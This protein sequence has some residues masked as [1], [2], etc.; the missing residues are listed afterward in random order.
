MEINIK[1]YLDWL[2]EFTKEYNSFSDDSFDY[3]DIPEIDKENS[4][5]EKIVFKKL[6]KLTYQKIAN[7]LFKDKN[8]YFI[9]TI[10][11]LI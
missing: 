3:K 2:N 5:F 10:Y 6:E 11:Y 9:D 4:T 1:D 7:K 8:H